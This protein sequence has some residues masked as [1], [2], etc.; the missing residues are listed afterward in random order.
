MIAISAR[1]GTSLFLKNDGSAWAMGD[2]ANGQLGDGTTNNKKTSEQIFSTGVVSIV[3][4]HHHSLFLK[5]DGSLWAVGD[6]SSGQL[7][8]GT[9]KNETTPEEVVSSG[10]VAIAGAEYFSLFVKSDGSLWAMGNNTS[11]Q[12]GDGTTTNHSPPEQIVASGVIAVAANGYH[13]MFLKND[14]SLWAMG[15]NS[16]GQLGDGTTTQ[17]DSPEQILASGVVGIAPGY[18]HSLF[19]KNDGSLWAV[20]SDGTGQL[21]DGT[22]TNR[23]TPEEILASGVSGITAGVGHSLFIKNYG[24]LWAMGYNQYG[25]LGDGT[26]TE[27]NIPEQILQG[28]ALPAVT[29][30]AINAAV[31]AG[32][33][34]TF[35]VAAGGSPNPTYQW[36]VS[37]DGGNTWSN[38]TDNSIYTGTATTT[39][40]VN[41]ATTAQLGYEFQAIVSNSVGSIISARA[42]LVVGSSSAKLTWLKNN[43]STAQMGEPSI[44]GDLGTP[45]NDGIPN[46][47]KYAFNLP[48][49]VNGQSLLPNPMAGNGNLSLMFQ[50]LQADLTYTVEASTDLTNWSATGVNTTIK[51][52][53]ETASYPIPTSNSTFLHIV[54]APSP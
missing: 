13:S 21:G 17:Q 1:S 5:S 34:P 9:T 28:F 26:T 33:S 16:A 12:L 31:I 20:G 11:G 53:T 52:G 50:P 6:N 43:F 37:A 8:D 7:G 23:S 29:T 15:D 27:S 40:T 51:A 25:Q 24:S 45:A 44:I 2:N 32:A 18:D 19:V 41:D 3:A 49:L 46:L 36:Q 48:A 38:L 10:V 14:G 54:I 39:L 4:C 22:T 30:Q 47:I 42:P 35:T